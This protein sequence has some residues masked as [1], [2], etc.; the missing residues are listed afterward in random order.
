[1]YIDIVYPLDTKIAIQ[2]ITLT[3][4]YYT[5]YVDFS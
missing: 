5:G 2:L 1:M 4:F 3:T